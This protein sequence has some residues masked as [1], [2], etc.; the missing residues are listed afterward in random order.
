L[1]VRPRPSWEARLSAPT[2]GVKREKKTHHEGVHKVHEEKQFDR[3][4]KSFQSN[5]IQNFVSFVNF[6]VK[7]SCGNS[8]SMRDN[9]QIFLQAENNG[10]AE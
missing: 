10:K 9:N 7:I 2:H 4:G 8:E 6:V 5:P 1:V 3:K